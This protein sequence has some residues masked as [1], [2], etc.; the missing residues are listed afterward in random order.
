MKI[1]IVTYFY[2]KSLL[3][4]TIFV[5]CEKVKKKL[6]F[7]NVSV[8]RVFLIETVSKAIG[9]DVRVKLIRLPDGVK[10]PS[11]SKH[12]CV[13]FGVPVKSIILFCCLWAPIILPFSFQV[14][15]SSRKVTTREHKT[16]LYYVSTNT[17]FSH[18]Q[19]LRSLKY[20]PKN[21]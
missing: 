8:C 15:M 1:Y 12:V 18:A 10:R 7:K 3:N 5:K 4:V 19:S 11:S 14:E 13:L 17:M 16:I 6:L 21:W 9:V 2:F 20:T